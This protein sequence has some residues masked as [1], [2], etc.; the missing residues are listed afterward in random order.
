MRTTGDIFWHVLVI[1]SNNLFKIIIFLGGK[2]Q[3]INIV[4]TFNLGVLGGILTSSFSTFHKVHVLCSKIYVKSPLTSE[5]SYFPLP[6][7]TCQHDFLKKLIIIIP[8]H[9]CTQEQWDLYQSI[10]FT[11]QYTTFWKKVK[12]FLHRFFFYRPIRTFTLKIEV[13]L[14]GCNY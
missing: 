14:R 9:S 11:H 8:K 13:V 4:S 7:I 1:F 12:K 2:L 3:K 5:K 6:V 10:L